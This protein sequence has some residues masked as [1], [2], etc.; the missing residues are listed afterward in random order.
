[1]SY[2][3]LRRPDRILGSRIIFPDATLFSK[4]SFYISTIF[5]GFGVKVTEEIV[6]EAKLVELNKALDLALLQSRA[7]QS[8]FSRNSAF[9]DQPQLFM[10]VAV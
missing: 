3:H 9:I 1:M 10:F 7:G 8:S 5:I 6:I 4:L 2:H